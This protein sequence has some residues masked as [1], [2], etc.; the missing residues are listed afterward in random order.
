MGAEAPIFDVAS[1]VDIHAL[2]ALLDR[3]DAI[4][5]MIIVGVTAPGPSQDR[6]AEFPEI[7]DGLLAI[8][9]HV[10]N[11]RFLADPQTAVHAG[12]EM[13]GKMTVKLRANDANLSIRAHDDSLCRRGSSEQASRNERREREGRGASN[14]L[15][16]R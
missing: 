5:P 12:T 3:P 10:G 15:A 9:F 2:G 8:A 4:T 1:P 16:T 11:W 13:L 6:D 14:K 7:L